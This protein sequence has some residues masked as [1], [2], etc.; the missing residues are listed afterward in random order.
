MGHL[1]LFHA[2]SQGDLEDLSGSKVLENNC[3][4]ALVITMSK[5][6]S[7]W[8][9]MFA[10]LFGVDAAG[11]WDYSLQQPLTDSLDDNE[12]TRLKHKLVLCVVPRNQKTSPDQGVVGARDLVRKL[13][14]FLGSAAASK[15]KVLQHL[16][17]DLAKEK[18]EKKAA[19]LDRK[20]ADQLGLTETQQEQIEGM[21]EATIRYLYDLTLGSKPD[22]TILNSISDTAISG[23]LVENKI[24]GPVCGVQIERH[25]RE[26]FRQGLIPEYYND[27]AETPCLNA[28]GKL[29]VRICTWPEIYSLCKTSKETEPDP[30]A[31]FVI[32]QFLEYLEVN[33]MGE[34]K[35]SRQDFLDWEKDTTPNQT[36]AHDLKE[37]LVSL[38]DGVGKLAG[39]YSVDPG[40]VVAN[41][42]YCSIVKNGKKRIDVPHFTLALDQNYA[43]NRCLRL[44]VQC[45]GKKPVLK[46]L[47]KQEAL[48][49][50]LPAVLKGLGRGFV[51]RVEM[52]IIAIV[53]GQTLGTGKGPNQPIYEIY[54]QMP[55]DLVKEG[56]MPAVVTEAFTAMRSINELP[57][58]DDVAF[59]PILQLNYNLNWH[60]LEA[61]G[62]GVEEKL[63]DAFKKLEPYYTRL[64]E[65]S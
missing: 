28:P 24:H 48:G 57:S 34:V 4:R 37:R 6:P 55:L 53:K 30:V 10:R 20:V 7:L 64:A 12:I 62:A 45:E 56:D 36:V 21:D 49:H 51:L 42:V 3:T 17:N 61:V 25:I 33:N 31:R 44:F 18:E 35:F 47:S 13:E 52:K 8:G 43:Q 14:E 26:N 38:A 40:A 41:T 46:L 27:L 32:D 2:Y 39:D 60:E 29:A 5:S 50:E 54:W 22:A 1:N 9:R 58:R 59:F 19:H 63:R 16:L 11:E 23:I 65:H 15:R